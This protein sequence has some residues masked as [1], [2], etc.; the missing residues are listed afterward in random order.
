[1][2]IEPRI[3]RSIDDFCT[4]GILVDCSR[5]VL[6]AYVLCL[7]LCFALGMLALFMQIKLHVQAL[8]L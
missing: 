5:R 3:V 8:V 6:E 4:V 1:M 7:L 2:L